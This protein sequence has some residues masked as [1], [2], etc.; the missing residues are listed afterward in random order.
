MGLVH[1]SYRDTFSSFV[2]ALEQFSKAHPDWTI[3]FVIRGGLSFPLPSVQFPIEVL[4]WGTEVEVEK[5]LDRIDLLYLPLPFSKAHQS[6]SRYSL[7]TKMVTYLGSGL[8]IIYHGPQDAAAGNLL[9]K[10]NAS[11]VFTS[12]DP[13]HIFKALEVSE[14]SLDRLVENALKLA[15]AQ[16]M[17]SD[18]QTIFWEVLLSSTDSP[19][20]KD[21]DQASLA[22]FIS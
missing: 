22:A 8:P 4:P 9:S 10:A 13:S 21:S 6:F 14:Q 17:L 20:R 2:L 7:S 18:V 11:L 15:Q 3:S 19:L 16:F 1:L 5:D 12:L